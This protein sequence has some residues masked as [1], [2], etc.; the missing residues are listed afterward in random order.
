MSNSTTN[1]KKDKTS[2]QVEPVKFDGQAKCLYVNTIDVSEK[3]G[4]LFAPV[5]ADYSGCKILVNNGLGGD[6]VNTSMPAGSLYVDLYFKE[7]A[8]NMDAPIKNLVRL[9][10][11]DTGTDLSNRLQRIIGGMSS[12][13][14]ELSKDTLEALEEFLPVNRNPRWKDRVVEHAVRVDAYSHEEIVVRV[15]GLSLE[16]LIRKIYG[17]EDVDPETGAKIRYDYS[18]VPLRQVF[19]TRD[20]MVLQITQLDQRVVADLSRSLGI[21]FQA[22]VDYNIYHGGYQR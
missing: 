3:I 2:L 4:S 17:V 13:I 21:N 22:P 7:G 1:E 11:K 6:V 20:E 15:V 10:E 19:N 16:A 5:F 18:I 8:G 9:S 14:Y 12:R